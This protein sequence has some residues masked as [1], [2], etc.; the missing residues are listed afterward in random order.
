MSSGVLNFDS[1]LT[2]NLID[3]C[4]DDKRTLTADLPAA[5]ER[6]LQLVNDAGDAVKVKSL[7]ISPLKD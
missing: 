7:E 4:V 2:S 5:S 6:S 3:I 1:V